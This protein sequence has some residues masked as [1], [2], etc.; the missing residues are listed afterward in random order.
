[1]SKADLVLLHAPSV[2]DF[3]ENSIMYGP[4]SDLV[5]SS[6]IFEMYPLGFTTMA[7]YMERHGLTVRI[8][9][10][11][12][13]MLSR[14]NFDVEKAIREMDPAVFG[15]DLHWAP[16]AH[17]S[18]EIAR[19]CKKYH[20]TTPVVFGGLT[21][22]YFHEELVSYPW[23][24]YVVRGDSTEEPFTR[25]IYALK[26]GGSVAD[27][28]NVTYKGLDGS[29]V[30]NPID[31]VP[32]T[33]DHVKLDY[34]FSMRSVIRD[35]DMMS[36]L[37]FKGWLSYPVSASL[38][39]RGCS[40][41]CATCGGSAVAFRNHFGR[42]SVAFRDP[43]LLVRDIGH[44]AKHIPGPVFVLN[45]FRQAG[46]EYVK[47]FIS[48]LRKIDF[49][50]PIGFEFFS[51]PEEAFYEF[52]DENL[53]DY[54]VEVSAESH[55]DAVRKAFGK[56]YAWDTLSDSIEAALKHNCKRFDLYFMTG[57]PTQ[58]AQS[59]RDTVPAVREL[60]ARVNDDKRL[61]AF[62]GPMAPFLDPGS[63]VFDDPDRYGYKLRAKTLEEHRQLLLEPSWKHILNYEPDGMTRDEMVDSTYE[64]A[65]GFNAIKAE[66]GI[67][68][69]K[70]ARQTEERIVEARKAMARIDAIMKHEPE[71][72]KVML[73][74]YKK[75]LDQ[76]NESTV[77]E[78]T[79]LN[80]PANV[81]WR[82]FVYNAL[83]WFR[84]NY[85]T[86]FPGT[87]KIDGRFMEDES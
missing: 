31:C 52:L 62:I 70:T 63:M 21:A 41:T 66:V 18:I 17:G 82:H 40:K 69:A 33:F 77:C 2:Y 55:D 72:R 34:S 71:E 84:V 76:L 11:A 61:L 73:A 47:A 44:I 56:P 60:Y 39:C 78:K 85:E 36:A 20:P 64:A 67:A 10:L 79:E 83:L 43:E 9:N 59:V 13:L 6:P 7:E 49:K 4:V 68:D 50:N 15:I 37:P 14:P 1:M 38:T 51:P 25:L 5:P 53:N 54:S 80:W 28:P 22:S 81:N 75:E 27:L 30:A 86:L 65:L 23:V 46:D 48:G 3:R 87:R 24:D 74:D 45:D 26:R 12:V 32:D 19:L 35:R 16:H 29:V 57:I 58:T 8:V 42:K